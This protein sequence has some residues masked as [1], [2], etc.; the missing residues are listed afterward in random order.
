VTTRIV[1]PTLCRSGTK[2]VV[3]LLHDVGFDETEL[4]DIHNPIS[5][6]CTF[7]GHIMETTSLAVQGMR[8]GYPAIIPLRHPYIMEESYRR[9]GRIKTPA[10]IWAIRNMI[11][12]F[13][14]LDPYWLPIDSP[15]R[16]SFLSVIERELDIEL[17]HEWPLINSSGKTPFLAWDGLKPSKGIVELMEEEPN[18]WYSLY[19]L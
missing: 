18:F 9:R 15:R 17:S 12:V 14:P 1:V 5:D 4:S 3:K 7:V 16:D 8:K 6:K 19:P 11:R 10:L 13:K 2:L